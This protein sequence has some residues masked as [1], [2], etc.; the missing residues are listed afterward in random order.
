M[1]T[2]R[3]LILIL[4]LLAGV[5]ALMGASA[6]KKRADTAT[7]QPTGWVSDTPWHLAKTKVYPQ[8]VPAWMARDYNV[9]YAS[10]IGT[11]S[12]RLV[13]DKLGDMEVIYTLGVSNKANG[14][15]TSMI[16]SYDLA[17]WG[18]TKQ[19]F[20]R[21]AVRAVEDLFRYVHGKAGRASSI[22]VGIVEKDKKSKEFELQDKGV[23]I[24]LV[25][26]YAEQNDPRGPHVTALLLAPHH[27]YKAAV[28][29]WVSSGRTPPDRLLAFVQ[30][31]KITLFEDKPEYERVFRRG[32]EKFNVSKFR[33]TLTTNLYL[34][35]PDFV[36]VALKNRSTRKPTYY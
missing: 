1:K 35:T 26:V 28:F 14:A 5:G 30:Q 4:A 17:R 32:I 24:P 11:D 20:T 36:E 18:V 22:K 6:P 12:V 16:W 9:Q 3:H 8:L 29:P 27:L 19:D 33:N 2:L 13:S 31:G 23:Q 7:G 25:D 21:H 15:H 10:Q 34:V